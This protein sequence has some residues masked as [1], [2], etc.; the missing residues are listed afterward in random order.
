MDEAV[1]RRKVRDLPI[2]VRPPLC[3]HNVELL[4]LCSLQEQS[5]HYSRITV[6]EN[7]AAVLRESNL[8]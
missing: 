5:G 7:C 8:I 3:Y 2:L 4:C 1:R 6:H